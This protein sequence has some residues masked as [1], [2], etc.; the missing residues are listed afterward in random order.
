MNFDNWAV[1]FT[2]NSKRAIEL[3]SIQYDGSSICI[4]LY[5]EDSDRNWKVTFDS[6]VAL[7]IVSEECSAGIQNDLPEEGAF[8]I[9]KKSDWLFELGKGDISF[10]DDAS[11]FVMCCYDEVIE[12]ISCRSDVSI[13]EQIEV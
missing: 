4:V 2:A 9:T 6:Y 8:Y 13:A 10:L 12:V 1:P 5:E 11:H 3:V 7:R